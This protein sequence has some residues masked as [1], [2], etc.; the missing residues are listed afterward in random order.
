MKI[1][2]VTFNNVKHIRKKLEPEKWE[3]VPL[4]M[5]G[6]YMADPSVLTT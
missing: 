6:S 3:E 5:N 4:V 1:P 2:D